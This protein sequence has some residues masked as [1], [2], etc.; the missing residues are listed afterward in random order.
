MVAA[1]GEGMALPASAEEKNGPVPAD[2]E[3]D[4]RTG[5]GSE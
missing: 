5:A 4:H 2:D 3:P 1:T